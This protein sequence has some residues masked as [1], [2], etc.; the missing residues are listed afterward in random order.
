MKQ[1]PSMNL[2]KYIALSGVAARRKA[3]LI[4]KEGLVTV[5]N[6]IVREPG[7]QVQPRDVVKY[8]D[9][10]IK[11]EQKVYIVLNKPKNYITT[12]ADERDRAT[13]MDLIHDKKLPRLF[14]VGR[15]DR[16]TTGLLLIT[17][18]GLL[19]QK[20]AHPRNC[21]S[22]AYRV[23]LDKPIGA[24]DLDK[25]HLGVPLPD[26]RIKPDKAYVVPG[27]NKYEIVIELH[28][29]KN[30]IVR[31]IF[32]F[33]GYKIRALDRFKLAGLTKQGLERG[34]WRFL[35]PIEIE[36]LAKQTKS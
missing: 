18:D 28:S 3:V 34:A 33:L 24:I 6:T 15:L 9:R 23:T 7:Y 21:I 13:V 5:N 35:K 10:I 17:N 19:A 4:I 14:P 2:C 29:G 20:L 16:D 8:E 12:L 22:K 1:S 26:G 36:R 32:E 11:P 30:R 25:L 31:R 27:S